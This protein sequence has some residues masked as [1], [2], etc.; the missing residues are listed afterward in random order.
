[1]Q[2][3]GR[4]GSQ[5]I[6]FARSGPWKTREAY[7]QTCEIGVY[8]RPE[9]HGKGVGKALYAALLPAL[10][11]CGFRTVLAGIALPNPASVRLHE[12]FGMTHFGTMHKVGYKFGQW[13]DVGYWELHWG[14]EP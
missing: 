4:G 14:E 6:G 3:E 5:L 1:M 11:E 7:S 2:P 13:W 8:V 12:S 9:F 10:R